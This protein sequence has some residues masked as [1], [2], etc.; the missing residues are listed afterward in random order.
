MHSSHRSTAL[1]QISEF[2][3]YGDRIGQK[4]IPSFT[5]A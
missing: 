3:L 1:I 4:Q 5:V 2:E